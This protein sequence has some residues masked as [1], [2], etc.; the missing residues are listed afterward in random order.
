M[1]QELQKKCVDTIRFLAI[2]AVEKANSGH[3][4]MPMGAAPMAFT[5]W[6]RHLRFNPNE[7]RWANRDRFILSAGHG[8][9]LLYALL[10]LSG[11]DVTME[12]LK[13]FR[14]WQSKTPGHPEFHDTPGVE[15]TTGPL[16][17]GISN[18]VG[19]ALSQRMLAARMNGGGQFPIENFIYGICSDG[20]LMEGVSN[21]AASLAGHLKLGNII[22]MY[23]D[24]HISLAGKTS[25]TFTEDRDKRYEALG[26]HVQHVADGNDLEAID[27]AIIAAKKDPRPSLISVRTV[28]GFGS[29]H[30]ADTHESHGSPLGKDEV[31]A[32]KQNLG[33]PLEPA[34]LVPDDVRAFWA[35]RIEEVKKGYEQWQQQFVEWKKA[36]VEK[37]KLWSALANR[38][39]PEDLPEQLAA[40]IASIT[41]AESTRKLGQAILQ[42]AAALVP[43]IAGGSA[44]LDP[45]T[46][47]YLKDLGDIA[48]DDYAGRNIH[49][50]VREHAMGATANGFAY[51]GFFI[52][53]TAT[54]LLF[55]DYMRP[56]IRL[57]ALSKIQSIFVFTHDS[58]FVGEDGPTH[59]PIEQLASLRAIPNLHVWRPADGLETAAAWAAAILRKDGPSLMAFS[60]Q[61][62]P[63]LDRTRPATVRDA[64]R[65]AYAV[66]DV[67]GEPDVVIVA[68]G[69]EVGAVQAALPLLNQSLQGLKVR[70]VSMPCVER[71]LQ[72][73]G[74][75]QRKLI[76]HDTKTKLVAVE[77]A[78]GL[79]WYRIVGAGMVCGIDRFGASAPEKALA[80]AFDLTPQKL[81]GKISKWLSEGARTNTK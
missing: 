65:G 32:T 41:A 19:F 51:D 16:G 1:N 50:G 57:A 11:Y 56:P 80:D 43:S 37:A 69:S 6:S 36:N 9:M 68:T 38:E 47:T 42:K 4:G 30:K 31:R 72:W 76:P 81:A 10:H 20:D 49:Y 23:D 54:F 26:W 79:D 18:A 24:N 59:Q 66:H 21:E 53:Y 75:E 35:G 27:Q 14:Q 8:S 28:L 15:A 29:P 78:G 55:S 63:V 44:D 52:P 45:S 34:F 7:P 25:I 46:F 60:R 39:V 62:L 73:P 12:D 64:M 61:K 74:E 67:E 13:S 71:F 17:Q 70:L 3:P 33:W 2:D 22:F 58:I 5:L 40:S 48:P 77:A